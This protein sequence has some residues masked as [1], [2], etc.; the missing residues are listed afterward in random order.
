LLFFPLPPMTQHVSQVRLEHAA[1]EEVRSD[2]DTLSLVADGLSELTVGEVG[3]SDHVVPLLAGHRLH[4]LPALAP[5]ATL[6]DA[7]VLA[8]SHCDQTI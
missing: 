8:D 2:A 5:L 6:G 7:L 1:T 3:R 4:D